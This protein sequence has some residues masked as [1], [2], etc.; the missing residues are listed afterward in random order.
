MDFAEFE[1]ELEA[2]RT[3]LAERDALIEALQDAVSQA[4][5]AIAQIEFSPEQGQSSAVFARLRI[6]LDRVSSR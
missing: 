2:L 1:R 5:T 3:R 6:L 4:A